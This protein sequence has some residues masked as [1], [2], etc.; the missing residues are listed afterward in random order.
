MSYWTYVDIDTGG[1]EALSVEIGNMTSNVSGMWAK[2]LTAATETVPAFASLKGAD[3]RRMLAER[4]E[5]DYYRDN[6]AAFEERLSLRDLAGHSARELV[7]LLEA[8]IAWGFEHLDD[9][10]ED[11]PDNGWGNAEGAL[12]YL[13]DIK[14]VCEAHPIGK[15]VVSS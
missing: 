8:A 1:P 6:L 14:N 7:P 13:L 3:A 4:P 10:R 15:L 12:L 2:C 9:L 5:L 11:N